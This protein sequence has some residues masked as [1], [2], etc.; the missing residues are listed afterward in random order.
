MSTAI[1]A[2]LIAAAAQGQSAQQ[3]ILKQLTDAKAFG[4]SSAVPLAP[5]DAAQEKA[6]TELLGLMTVRPWNGG[7]YLDRDRQKEREQQQGWIA[8]V[9]LVVIASVVAT[10]V[11]LLAL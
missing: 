1:N 3:A 11:A 4:P 6:L 9:I 2:A 8:L 7:Y 10:A 5:N